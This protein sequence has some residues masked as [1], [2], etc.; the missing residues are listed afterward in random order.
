MRIRPALTA[1]GL[2]G[3]VA[4]FFFCSVP[5]VEASGSQNATLTLNAAVTPNC[6]SS[7][8]SPNTISY[9]PLGANSG[10]PAEDSSGQLLLECTRKAAITIDLDAGLHSTASGTSWFQPNM[11]GAVNHNLLKYA[12]YKDAGYS[13]LW[14]S[15]TST[16]GTAAGSVQTT[17]G[18]GPGSSHVITLS[19][20]IQIPPA[21]A[22]TAD[23]Y[24]DTMTARISY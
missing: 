11:Y 10:S 4:L 13:Q 17:T 14:G 5:R 20:Y 9:D 2:A 1:L 7:V 23:G 24:S 16:T 6:T 21:Q 22:L 18:L 3:A 15:T 8:V 19:L 12:I